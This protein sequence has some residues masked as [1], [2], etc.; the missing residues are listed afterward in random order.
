MISSEPAG[1]RTPLI[2][3]IE[4]RGF[5]MQ[6]T[7][8]ITDTDVA[9]IKAFI[10]KHA[11]NSF[12]RYRIKRNV[13]NRP[14]S[15]DRSGFWYCVVAC[16]LTTQQR[17]GPKSQVTRFLNSD[18][19]P[20]S[21]DLCRSCENVTNLAQKVLTDHGGI[22]FAPKIAAQLKE[23]LEWLEDQWWPKVDTVLCKLISA[24]DPKAERE[25]AHFI[26]YEFYGFGPK[27]SRNLLQ[28]L[29]L[30]RYEI[31]LD[32]RVAKWLNKFGF[33]IRLSAGSLADEG[34]YEFLSDGIQELCR[35]C[36]ILPCVL[37]GAVFASFDDKGDG[38][39]WGKLNQ[40][41]W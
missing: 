20:L 2:S 11:D 13:T 41:I 25:A 3:D 33:P 34:V 40:I 7:W 9:N 8:S 38:D 24:N 37:D 19:F 32:S 21:L 26:D 4:L 30:T 12:V 17:S 5:L 1:Y 6:I 29:G 22:R 18:P 23:N 15:I 10:D 39:S 27:Q 28:M 16:L 35:R 14:T 36:D 31:P